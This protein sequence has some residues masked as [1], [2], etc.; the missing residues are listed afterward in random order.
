MALC[1]VSC[2]AIQIMHESYKTRN[3][4]IMRHY[5]K[6]HIW[7]RR[8]NILNFSGWAF[9]NAFWDG[10]SLLEDRKPP[11]SWVP[12]ENPTAQMNHF[13]KQKW[14]DLQISHLERCCMPPER[15]ITGGGSVTFKK[16]KKI[17][18]IMWRWNVFPRQL[19]PVTINDVWTLP[20]CFRLL[21][22]THDGGRRPFCH[23]FF[24]NQRGLPAED[25]KVWTMQKNAK[26]WNITWAESKESV[27]KKA[28]RNKY[29][30]HARSRE[31]L[32]SSERSKVSR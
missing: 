13:A 10:D 4:H 14:A 18:A 16:I 2:F 6:L 1:Y 27:L 19:T 22:Q 29:R 24:L 21:T 28:M 3:S 30:Q 23:F 15:A 11:R 20:C 25:K 12:W 32:H 9:S 5:V 26:D 8:K 7:A 17:K 31:W